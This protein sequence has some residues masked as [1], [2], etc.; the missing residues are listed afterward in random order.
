MLNIE[1]WR[2]I[3]MQYA[4]NVYGQRTIVKRDDRFN[5]KVTIFGGG[6]DPRVGKRPVRIADK[7]RNI[8]NKIK[9]AFCISLI[10]A[11]AYMC[12]A[13][14][15]QNLPAVEKTETP[16]Q[17]DEEPAS[18][19]LNGAVSYQ[20]ADMPRDTISRDGRNYDQNQQIEDL[21][22]KYFGKDAETAIKIADCETTGCG[23]HKYDAYIINDNPKTE[24]Y[25]VGVFQINLFGKLAL[26]RPS[27]E[28]LQNP[29]N[30]IQFAKTL[31]DGSKG[32]FKVDWAT[33]CRKLSI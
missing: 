16:A 2:E 19:P 24:D 27:V 31:F 29:E 10:A 12:N 25:S 28:W 21:I 22:R 3:K 13:N 30:N 1:H 18:K 4:I 33:S 8:I 26:T 15:K 23:D 20:S 32:N 5:K 9:I 11:T 14:A 6:S 17:Q 7:A